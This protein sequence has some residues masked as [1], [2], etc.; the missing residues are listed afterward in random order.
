MRGLV[1]LFDS[2]GGKSNQEDDGS[3]DEDERCFV[4]VW[5]RNFEGARKEQRESAKNECADRTKR[6]ESDKAGAEKFVNAIFTGAGGG[7]HIGL[8]QHARYTHVKKVERGGERHDEKKK[9]VLDD[10]DFANYIPGETQ[11]ECNLAGVSGVVPGD[12]RSR[13]RSRGRW[14]GIGLPLA[15]HRGDHYTKR[16]FVKCLVAGKAGF[17]R[18]GAI[19]S[20]KRGVEGDTSSLCAETPSIRRGWLQHGS[21]DDP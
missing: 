14:A 1:D 9:A 21:K 20:S 15:R 8:D 17:R 7:F 13:M 19:L 3:D 11:V 6:A 12:A 18:G 5:R 2:D 10:A 4:Q 16:G